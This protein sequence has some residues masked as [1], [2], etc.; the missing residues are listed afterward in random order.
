MNTYR[1]ED[2]EITPLDKD[3]E[4]MLIKAGWEKVE[5]KQEEK[6]KPKKKV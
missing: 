4:Q 5:E 1:K 2:K 3:M 6:P